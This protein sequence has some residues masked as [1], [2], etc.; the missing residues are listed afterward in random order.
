MKYTKDFKKQWQ[1]DLWRNACDKYDTVI[2]NHTPIPN[3]RYKAFV[4]KIWHYFCW[5]FKI[6]VI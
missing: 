5:T 4:Q 1:K 2:V 3:N 6:W